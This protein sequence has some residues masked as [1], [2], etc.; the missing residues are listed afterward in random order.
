MSE[1]NLPVEIDEAAQAELTENPAEA[2]EEE[3]GSVE[4]PVEA[5]EAE[6]GEEEGDIDPLEKF[7]NEIMMIPG[8][9]YVLHTYSGHERK[10]KANLEQRVQSQNMTDKVF[11]VEVPDEY[12]TEFRGSVKK[13]VRH[14]RIPGYV[15]V[16]MDFDEE[17]YRMVK[18][19]PAITGFVG[20]Q[21]NPVPLSIDE[22]VDLLKYNILEEA[23]PQV[24]AVAQVKEEIR[25]A[26]EVG[27][28]VTVID[29]PFESLEATISEISPETEKL[30]V[31]VM[32]FERETPL[33]L[34]FDQVAKRED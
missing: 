20:D 30:K 33:E 12:I 9:W 14:V 24:P 29:G 18:D 26:F 32:I 28:I 34:G 31:L 2:A 4:Q 6:A 25:V 10:V 3:A 17:S 5:E 15:V 13:R 11:R 16:C 1:E 23:G 27:E 19:T 22:V 21:H 8:D 7:R